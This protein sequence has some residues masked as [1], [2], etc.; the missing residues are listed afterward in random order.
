MPH[1][2]LCCRD[3]EHTVNVV[4]ALTQ[5]SQHFYISLPAKRK[6]E[7]EGNLGDGFW[8]ELKQ[9]TEESNTKV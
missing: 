2:H 9:R 5:I 8:T 7:A 1:L 4:C 3:P 6:A